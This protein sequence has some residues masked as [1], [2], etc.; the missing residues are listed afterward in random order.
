M[1]TEKDAGKVKVIYIAGC[2]RSGSTLLA[3]MLGQIP[4]FE[5]VGELK[6]IWQRNFAE[7]QLCGCGQPFRECDFWTAVVADAFGGFDTIDGRQMRQQQLA[8]DRVRHVP[9][10]LWTHSDTSSDYW[11]QERIYAAALQ[12]LYSSIARVSGKRIIVDSSKDVSTPFLLA[13]MPGIDLYTLHLIRDSRGVAYSWTKKKARVEIAD[14]TEYMHQ[15]SPLFSARRWLGWNS[16]IQAG[17]GR[18]TPEHYMRL[19]YEDFIDAPVETLRRITA[20]VGKPD[21]DLAFVSERSVQFSVVNHTVAGNP[22]RFQSGAVQL[23]QDEAWKEKMEP[24]ARR[25]VTAVTFPLLASYG[26]L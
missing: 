23:R 12:H 8:V 17:F 2:G 20:A 11:Q 7:N 1:Q 18:R 24:G 19:R 16:L 21:A 5:A 6:H 26:Y 15:Y 25:L 4:E 9:R 3:R 14:R 13:R 10:M 22:N